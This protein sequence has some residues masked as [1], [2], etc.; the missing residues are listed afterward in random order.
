MNRIAPAEI[1]RFLPQ[2]NSHSI[3]LRYESGALAGTFERDQIMHLAAQ[4]A[5]AGVLDRRGT[6]LRYCM[7]LIS[8]RAI[9]RMVKVRSATSIVAEDCQT[10]VFHPGPNGGTYSHNLKRSY[11]YAR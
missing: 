10:I 8:I 6:R 3:E 1:L 11:A 5:V 2:D 4:E 9:H 7:P